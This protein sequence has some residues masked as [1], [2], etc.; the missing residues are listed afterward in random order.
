[1]TAVGAWISRVD[2][3]EFGWGCNARGVVAH[4]HTLLPTEHMI[5][6]YT[7]GLKI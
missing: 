5:H 7:L 1:M 2:L 3:A 6:I 4:Y